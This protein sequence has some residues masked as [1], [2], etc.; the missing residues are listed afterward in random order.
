MK[1]LLS[2]LKGAE[3]VVIFPEGTYVREGSGGREEPVDSDDPWNSIGTQ[4]NGSHSF[5]WAF[6]MEEG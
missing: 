3:K 1:Y 5:R 6:D 2:S 4:G